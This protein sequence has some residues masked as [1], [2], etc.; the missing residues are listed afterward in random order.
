MAGWGIDLLKHD[1]TAYDL[2]G[3]WGFTMK[4]RPHALRQPFHDRSRTTAEITLA[5]YRTIA[6]A[7]GQA[8]VIGSIRS[9]TCRPACSKSSGPATTRAANGGSARATWA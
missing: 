8:A 5:L 7:S 9:A 3:Q 1:F 4:S 2:L 6:E